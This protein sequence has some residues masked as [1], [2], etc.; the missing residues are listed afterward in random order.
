MHESTMVR[1]EW[2]VQ[3]FC[4]YKQKT[5]IKILDVGSYDVN[6][7]YKQ[8]FYDERFMYTGLDMSKGPNVDIF[9]KNPYCW[10]E[11]P[12]NDYDI[13]ISGQA[14][15]HIEFPWIT[16][17]EIARVTKPGG[18]VCIISPRG[19][20]IHRYPVDTFRY[21]VDGM[22]ALAKYSGLEPVHVSTNLAP[23]NAPVSWYSGFQDCM[24]VGRRTLSK[25]IIDEYK[26]V[27][28]DI[29]V[30]STDFIPLEFQPYYKNIILERYSL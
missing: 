24:F 21:D 29:R 10:D 6:G 15:E 7:S 22:I 12:D 13:V 26:Y 8:F 20:G 3:T 28:V 4:N 17:K 1:M 11:V 9:V 25:F 16:I 14:F 2:F 18:F 23:K 30:L 5:P 19:Q 27:P